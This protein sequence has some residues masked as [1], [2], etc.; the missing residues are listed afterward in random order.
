MLYFA[1]GSNLRSSQMMRICPGHKFLAPARLDGHRLAFTLPDDEW[2]GGVADAVPSSGDHIYG[3]LYDISAND[4]ARLDEYEGFDPSN[5]EARHD[6]LR[7]KI[8]VTTLNQ[9]RH[10]GVWCY[11]VHL[12]RTHVAPSGLYCAAL[13]EGARERQLP[14]TYLKRLT[15][16]LQQ[17]MGR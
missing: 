7:L 11:F 1:Y 17:S 13:N 5:S 6:Y 15:T 3:A 2:Q 9:E 8:N 4:I 12:P 16:L 14:D 10:H